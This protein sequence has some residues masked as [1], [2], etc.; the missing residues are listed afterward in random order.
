MK[1]D[2]VFNI[3]KKEYSIAFTN[4]DL[5]KM[6]RSIGRSLLSMFGG[7]GNHLVEA[8]TIDVMAS[9]VVCGV[10]DLGKEDPYDFIQRYCD[11]GGDIDS[12]GGI[13]LDA[14]L[15]TGLFTRGKAARKVEKAPDKP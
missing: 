13:V 5:A 14:L 3:G 11:E 9:A 4:R 7:T 12:F 2:T 1:K 15:A 8:M 6:E 10:K